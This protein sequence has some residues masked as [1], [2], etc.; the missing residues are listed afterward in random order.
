MQGESAEMAKPPVDRELGRL[1]ELHY[2]EVLAYC[3][4]RIGRNDADDAVAEVFAVAWRRHNEIEWET[5]RPWLFGVARGVLA[6]LRR[7]AH[8][9]DRLVGKVAGLAPRLADP[10]DLQVVRR[11]EDEEV[12][13]A[14]RRLKERD[15]EVLMLTAWEEL[16]APQIA[17]ALGISVS[18]AEQRIHRAKRRLAKL[19]KP[20]TPD[21]SHPEAGGS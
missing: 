14:L 1:Y 18:A 3:V 10:P 4:R 20:A 15:Q 12:I 16:T 21:R 8:R 7:S 9:R 11:Y 13:T 2:P 5:A 17:V 19:L 6:N